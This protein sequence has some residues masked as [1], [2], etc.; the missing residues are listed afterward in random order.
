[1]QTN[2]LADTGNKDPVLNCIL[3]KEAGSAKIECSSVEEANRLAL[4]KSIILFGVI[5]K[6]AKFMETN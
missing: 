6:V 3:N 5:V 1:M 4:L 2:Y